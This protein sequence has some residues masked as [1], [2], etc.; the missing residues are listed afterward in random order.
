MKPA[1]APPNVNSARQAIHAIRGYEYQILAAA[2]AWVDLEENGL[3]YLEVAEDYARAVGGDIEAVQVKATRSSDTVTLNTPAVRNAIES[4]VDLAAQN[5]ERQ[6]QLRYLTT[7]PI[8]LEKSLEDRL[9]G[10]S[11]LVYWQRVRAGRE[12]VGPLRAILE[13]ESSPSAVRAFCK[14]RTDEELRA[15]LIRRITWDCDRPETSTLRRELQERVSL[16]L[17]KEFS[18]PLQEAQPIADVLASRVLQRSAMPDTR[19]RLL[20]RTELLQLAES[21]TRVSLQRA[22][23]ERLLHKALLAPDASTPDHAILSTQGRSYPPWMVSAEALPTP[24]ALVR[25][26]PLEKLAQSA[27]QSTGLCFFVGPTGTGKS[28]LAGSV[29]GTFPGSYYWVDLRDAESSEAKRRLNHLFPLLAELGPATL[30]LDDLNALSDPSVQLSLG[31]VVRAAR[32]RDMRTIVTSYARPTATALNRLNADRD[33]IVSSTNFNLEETF[34]LVNILGGDPNVWGRVSHVA[35][36]SGHPQLTHAFIAGMAAQ[37]WPSSQ[38]PEIVRRGFISDDIED[39]H[40]AARTNLINSLPEP[41]RE[42]LYRL[43]VATGPFQRSLAVAMGELQPRIERATEHFDQLVGRWLETPMADRFRT[44]PLVRGLG[45]K[46]LTT[47]QL[48]RVHD[49]IATDM[50][51]RNHIDAADI[52]AILIH[53]LAGESQQSLVKLTHAINSAGHDTRRSIA[54][55]LMVFPALDASKPIYPKDP[56]MSVL[57][58]LAQL[59]LAM[60]TKKR[61]RVDDIAETL[62]CEADTLPPDPERPDLQMAVLAAVLNNVG[63]ARHIRDWVD[64]LVRFRHLNRQGDAGVSTRNP[65]TPPAAALFSIGTAGLDSVKTLEAVFKDLSKLE[66]DERRELLTPIDAS[67]QDYQLLVHHPWTARSRQ[68]GFDATEALQ[69]YERMSAQTDSWGLRT[70]TVQCRVAVAMILDEHLEDTPRALHVLKEVETKFG[71]DAV[72]ARAL[73]KLHWRSGNG[74]EALHY[75]RDAVAHMSEF[76]PVDAVYTVREAAVCAAENDDWN[77]AHNWF[78]RAYTASNSFD[79]IGRSAIRVGLRADAAV[80]SFLAG[81]LRGALELLKQALHSL[82][83]IEPETDLQAAHCHRLIRH[84]ILWLQAKVEG[85]DT[86]VA[87]EPIAMRP[88][89]CSNPEPVPEIRQQPLGHIDFAWYMLASIEVASGL[90]VG[91]QQIVRQLGAH[92]FIPISEHAY[93]IQI[94]GATISAQDPKRFSLNLSDYLASATYCVTNR[95]VVS[96]S[97]NILNPQRVVI[98]AIPTN[99]PY[100][101]VTERSAFHAMLAYAVRSFLAEDLNAIDQLRDSLSREFGRSHPGMSFYAN[102]DAENTDPKDLDAVV[103]SIIRRC[104]LSK[105]PA[106]NLIFL[107]GLRLL[108]WVTQS[109]FKSV[110]IPHLKPW[111][112]EHWTRILQTQRFLLY[113]PASSVPPIE[114]VLRSELNG[115]QFAASLTLVAAVAVQARLSAPLRQDVLQLAHGTSN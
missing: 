29:A 76:G 39:E 85:L 71:H 2:L 115:E 30:I 63:I 108:T 50:T 1:L 45:Q 111:L 75:F 21:S 56:T 72:L 23:F 54:E 26:A 93:R 77:T 11:G 88:G 105:R 80:A 31:E 107:T 87:G 91:V 10:I 14:A 48:R 20:S 22:D 47:D 17:L 83:K 55:Y 46:M 109:P 32:R 64:L 90:D 8:G 89:A 24:G 57:L 110:L 99:D 35:G 94:L 67:V 33:C 112:M 37:G 34:A 28:L 25:R 5:P 114:E 61:R 9:G 49:K 16:F 97:M 60:A 92:G 62:L 58:R 42:L 73:A 59:Q 4:F 27:L 44:S 15:D 52:D 51:S 40:S 66:D 6:V 36:G 82:Q 70:L 3:I 96:R 18:V 104:S 95:D 12:D 38:I 19:D 103:C 41:A 102:S 69:R 84:T 53:G 86:K 98:P 106:P 81:D 65:E 68:P 7:S 101:V 43:S 79:S 74:S 78:L 113:S 13:R 100:D